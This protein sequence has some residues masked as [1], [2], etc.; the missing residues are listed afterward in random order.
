MSTTLDT[1]HAVIHE[2]E[3]KRYK[4]VLDQDYDQ[5]E[6]LCHAKLTYGHT[7][8]N[9]DSL[10]TYLGKLRGGTLRYHR[11]EHAI[12]D[13]VRVGDV[14]LVTGQ[15]SAEITVSGSRRT[16]KNSYLAVWVT[17]AEAWKFLAY[18]PTPLTA[19]AAASPRPAQVRQEMDTKS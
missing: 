10:A 6:G 15:M 5:F 18:Q 3:N 1:G 17:D 19:A 7:G 4:A 13:I 16:L 8:G 2:L 11:I 12:A 9:R 14:S